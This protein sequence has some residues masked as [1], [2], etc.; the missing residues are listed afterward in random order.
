MF[1]K[2]NN[3]GVTSVPPSSQVGSGLLFS[4]EVNNIPITNNIIKNIF[5]ISIYLRLF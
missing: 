1:Y 4:H 2:I 5:F 3:Y